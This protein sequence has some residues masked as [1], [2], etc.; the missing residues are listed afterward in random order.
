MG[1]E[2][3]LYNRLVE[4]FNLPPIAARAVV[5]LSMDVLLD[6]NKTPGSF[7]HM[8]YIAISDTEGLGKKIVGSAKIEVVLTLDAPEDRE[9]HQE[10]DLQT[11]RLF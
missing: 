2:E 7:G 4:G 11:L 1:R 5:A 9:T 8:K 3:L 10:Y 6:D